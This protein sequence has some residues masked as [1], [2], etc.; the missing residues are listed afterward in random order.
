LVEVGID[1]FQYR[2]QGQDHE[3]QQQVGQPQDHRGFGIK[4]P[5]GRLDQAQLQQHRIQQPLGAEN[6]LDG[7]G[8]DQGVGPERNDYQQ[9]QQVTPALRRLGDEV[10]ERIRQQ[11][12]QQGGDHRHPQGVDKHLQIDR[13]EQALVVFPGVVPT[14]ELTFIPGED[15]QHQDHQVGNQHEQDQ[16]DA[17]QQNRQ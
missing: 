1:L 4:E 16:P 7:I 5:Q 14:V 15:T 13:I 9:Q 6:D 3:G 12:A 2:E 8:A 17:D 10:G 11:Q